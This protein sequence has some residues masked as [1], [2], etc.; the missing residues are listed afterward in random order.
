MVNPARTSASRRLVVLA[1]ALIVVFGSAF[2]LTAQAPAKKA[3]SVDDY[4]KWRS[5]GGPSISGDGKWV[6]YVLSQRIRRRPT[7]SRSCICLRLDT[8]QDLEIPN[9]TA[10]R[11]LGRLAWLAYRSIRGGGRGGRGGRA[12]A[13]AALSAARRPGRARACG[14]EAAEWTRR[15]G[16]AS[17]ATASR[18]V[19]QSRDRHGAIVARHPVVHFRRDVESS[20]LRRRPAMPGRGRGGAGGGARRRAG[21]RRGAGA[22]R[23]AAPAGPR[24]ADVILHDLVSGRD[25]LLGSVGESSFNKKGDLLAYTVDAA[26][27]DGNGLFVLD[28]RNGRVTARQRRAC[29]QPAH[30]ERRGHRARRA[31]GRGRRQDARARQHAARV[32]NVQAALGDTEYAPVKLDPSKAEGSRRAGS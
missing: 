32:P 14:R 26:V 15:H 1:S 28:L 24:G 27:R 8:N 9:A 31:Q 6:A 16:R 7:R 22:G 21:G 13:V 4:T 17:G 20:L 30:V 19:A 23:E 11:L 25:Q 29:L 5:I 10:P 3:L 18:R 2:A 12:G